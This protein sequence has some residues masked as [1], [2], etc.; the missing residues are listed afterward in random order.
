MIG[1]VLLLFG[2]SIFIVVGTGIAVNINDFL[3]RKKSAGD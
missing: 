2:M 3:W 1:I